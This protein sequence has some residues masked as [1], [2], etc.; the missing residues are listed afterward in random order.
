MKNLFRSSQWNVMDISQAPK[1]QNN[2]KF[3]LS[4]GKRSCLT[5]DIFLHAF[6]K[7]NQYNI[8]YPSKTTK[9]WLFYYGVELFVLFS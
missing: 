7:F 6:L 3:S 4:H 8:Y 1:L 2:W 5:K 9:L